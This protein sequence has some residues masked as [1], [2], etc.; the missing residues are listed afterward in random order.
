MVPGEKR[1]YNIISITFSGSVA[2]LKIRSR[3]DSMNDQPHPV[4]QPKSL[5][6]KQ[7]V[8]YKINLEKKQMSDII[9]TLDNE[10]HRS[11]DYR[12]GF[13]SMKKYNSNPISLKFSDQ[14]LQKLSPI[15]DADFIIENVKTPMSEV[16]YAYLLE[17]HT[18]KCNRSDVQELLQN[19]TY[20]NSSNKLVTYAIRDAQH[21]LNIQSWRKQA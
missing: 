15:D 13:I 5:N 19:P 8:E 18:S 16:E 14:Y 3:E 10:I 17:A 12:N 11:G 9:L 6:G 2:T 20:K 1:Q 7:F 21:K 4:W